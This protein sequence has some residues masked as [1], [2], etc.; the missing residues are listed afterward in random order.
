M[1]SCAGTEHLSGKTLYHSGQTSDLAAVLGALKGRAPVFL[2][3]FSLGGNVV[4]KLAGELG[5]AAKGLIA[6]VTAV[7]TPIDLAACARRL[8]ARSNFIYSNRFLRR[9]KQR[10]ALKER[11]YARNLFARRPGPREQRL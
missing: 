7:S 8:Q 10:V 3:G 6:G 2:A 11:L 4:L 5:E 9:L 1:R